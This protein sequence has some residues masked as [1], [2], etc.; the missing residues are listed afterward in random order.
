[1]RYFGFVLFSAQIRS[2]AKGDSSAKT[3]LKIIKQA[4]KKAEK[5]GGK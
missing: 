2:I 1:M 4:A 3:A 5:Y